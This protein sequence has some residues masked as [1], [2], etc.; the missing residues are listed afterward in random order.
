MLFVE[1]KTLL[2]L[3]GFSDLEKN[4]ITALVSFIIF[5][6]PEHI[7]LI[8]CELCLIDVSCGLMSIN[9]T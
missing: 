8:G 6:Y 1:K 2:C 3:E 9:L 5:S 4:I 7:L